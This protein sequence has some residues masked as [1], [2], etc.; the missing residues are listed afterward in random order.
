MG[1][2]AIVEP[3]IELP[4]GSLIGLEKG[5]YPWEEES[6][7]AGTYIQPCTDI[8]GKYRGVQP[9]TAIEA[10]IHQWTNTYAGYIYMYI[11]YYIIRPTS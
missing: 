6:A 1:K 4:S 7:K 2:T 8:R 3:S 11:I 10:K 5:P 9:C